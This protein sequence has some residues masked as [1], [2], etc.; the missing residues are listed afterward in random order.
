MDFEVWILLLFFL[1]SNAQILVSKKELSVN[2]GRNVF[3][4]K[5][6]LVFVDTAKKSE[7]R[8]EVVQNDP[9]TQRVGQVRPIMFDCSF[10]PNTVQYI[11]SGSPLLNSDKVKLR[12]YKFTNNSTTSQTFHLDVQIAN[13]SH[14]IVVTRGLR[15]I[16]VP[17][18]NGLS[19]LIDSSV[20]RFYFSGKNNVSCTV[21]FSTYRSLWPIAGQ[22]VVGERKTRVETMRKSCRDFL[23]SKLYYQHVQSPNPDVDYLPLTI[24]LKD[25]DVSDDVSIERFYLPIHIKGALPNSP[26]RSSFL[27]IY[28]MDVNQFVLSTLLPGVISAEDYE[29]DSKD[30]VY[31]ITSLPGGNGGYFVHLDD[32]TIPIDSFVQDDLEHHRIAYQ[33]PSTSLSERRV[34]QAQFTVSD[35]HF[36]SSLPIVLHIAV[37]PSATNAPRIATN[38][39]LVLL[40]GQSRPITIAEL[41]ILDPDNANSVSLYVLGGLRYGQLMKNKRSTIA[42]TL[43]DL[44][45]GRISY[46]HDDS[47]STKDHIKF[48][49]SDGVNT[50]MIT[51]PIIII[52]KDDSAPYL[53]NSIG[54]EVN[55]GETRRISTNMLL[56]HDTDS[57]DD[58]IMYIITQPPSAGEIIKKTSQ[59]DTGTRISKFNQRNIK[60][61]QIFYRHFGNEV[62][63]DSFVFKLR[64]HQDPPNKSEDETF[65]IIINPVYENPPQ[66]APKATRL[67][68]VPETDITYI[69]KDELQ[70]TDIETDDNKLT[71]IITSP[72][73]FV[74]NAGFEEAGRIIATHNFSSVTKNDSIPAISTFKQEDINH[75]KIAYMPPLADIG[76]E[77]RLVRFVY[78]VQDSSGNQVLGQ[79]F[80]I[81]VQPVNDKPP[82]LLVSK[83]L[84]EEGGILGI[85][86]LQLSALDEDTLLED[87]VFILDETPKYGVVQKNGMALAQ[88]G[89]FKID[90]LR[91]NDIRY[92]HDGA[93]VLLDSITL[94]VSDGVNRATKVVP[95]DIVPIDDKAPLL[96][97][98]L[99]P[100]LIVSEGGDAIVTS[101]VLAATDDDTDDS[102]LIF[103]IVK[104]PKYGIMQLVDQP[105]TKFTQK[106]VNGNKVKYIHTGGEVGNNILRDTV[107]FIVSDQN[108]MATGDLPVYDLNITITPVDNSKPA[109]IK[110]L[111]LVV[112]EGGSVTLTPDAVTAKDPDTDPEEIS[113]VITKQPQWGYL[114]NSKPL[115]GS[116]KSRSGIRITTFKLQDIIDKTINYVQANHKGVEPIYDEVEFYATDGKQRSDD[117]PLGFRITP[118]N[119]E[120][121]DVMLQDFSVD[122]GSFKIIDQIIVDAID[123]DVPKEQ[124]TL[125]I[126]QAPDHGDIVLMIQ[127]KNGDMEV[128]VH[129]FTVEELHKG[130]RLKY[131]HDNSEHFRDKFALTVSDGR[132]EVKKLCNISIRA[133]NDEGP[134][135]T[136]NAGLQLEYGDFA[137]ISSASLQS[138]DPDN[139]DNEVIYILMSVPKKGSLQFCTDPFSPTRISECRD[140][141]VGQN[142]TQ[143]DVDMNRVRY[144]HTTSMGNTETDSFL[145]LLTDGTNR[146][147]VE[148]FEIRIRNSKKS[149]LA[150]FNKGLQVRE[151]ERTSISTNNLSASDESTKA[152]EIVF[153]I[154]QRPRLGQIEFIDRHLTSINSF[155]QLDL[156][157]RKVVYNNLNKGDN[158]EDVFKFTVTNGLSQAKDGEF[159]ITIEPLDRVLPSLRVNSLIEVTQGG[160]VELSPLLLK[161]QDPDTASTNVTFI[162]AKPP[163]YGRLYN[164]GIVITR[165]FT[166]S[167]INFGFI[168]YETD[169][170]H[171]GLDNFLFNISDGKHAGFLVNGTLQTKPVICSI[172]I[173][174]LVNDA[175][176]L[177]IL[178]QPDTLEFFGNDRYGFR[179]TNRNLKAIDSDST[180]SQLTYNMI[181]KPQ[182]GHVENVKTKRYVRRRFTQKDVDE[183]SLHYIVNQRKAH[184]NDS[185]T[186]SVTDSRGNILNNQRFEMKW[187]R[188]EFLRKQ[189]ISCEDIGTLTITLKRTGDL[190]QISFVGIKIRDMS[191]KSG[192][193]FFPSSAKQVQFNPGMNQ[194]TWDIR[195]AADSLMENSEKF[196][197]YLEEPINA[198]LGRRTK[199]NIHLI[200]AENGECPQYLGM[201]SKNNKDVV[202]LEETITPISNKKIDTKL[203]FNTF[204]GLGTIKENPLDNAYNTDPDSTPSKSSLSSSKKS[205]T[206][207]NSELNE[208]LPTK[209]KQKKRKRKGRKRKKKRNGKIKKSNSLSQ[210]ADSIFPLSSS[211]LRIQAPQNCTRTTKNL[212]HFDSFTQRM[213]KC[214][215]Y[216]WRVW[217]SG[218]PDE[219]AISSIPAPSVCLIGEFFEGRCYKFFKERKTWEE[220]KRHCNSINAIPSTLTPV[221]SR[222]HYQFLVKLAGKTSF[223]IGLN[224]KQ[225]PRDWEYLRDGSSSIPLL[226][227]TNWGKNQPQVRGKRDRRNCVLVNKRRKWKNKSCTKNS[228]RFIC[229]G[230]PHQK[231]PSQQF[232]VSDQPR[233]QRGRR[234]RRFRWSN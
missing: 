5:D 232:S 190:Q 125:S 31:N 127:T 54:L 197:I 233:R 51:F 167:D 146:R 91:R 163:T 79:Y 128:A 63:K 3:L 123:M 1:T 102:Q 88:K 61:G 196:Q 224:N 171:A 124:L 227:Y 115:K 226:S 4:R 114:E 126:S 81:D 34:F 140:M 187:S 92:V 135:I 117:V 180:S 60:K 155:T 101:S 32:H 40:E 8:V 166:Q 148:T 84:V 20:I 151:G 170:S 72:P 14:D 165:S 223:W 225:A 66:L 97:S 191:A 160:E 131:K 59:G 99:R 7:C 42:M 216:I 80:E 37:R 28:M 118:Q 41:N 206:I 50:I 173:K 158:T 172:F 75:M 199:M 11:H 90:D 26:P 46:Q 65:H 174:P 186:F 229:E 113:F 161:A 183:S 62:F 221:R 106:D 17:E 156:A 86:N 93:E 16:V 230:I 96:K 49:I 154:T 142:F 70:Y 228:K 177:L 150:V 159:R 204:S 53:V 116:Q 157:S 104:Q 107:T 98:N 189:I 207:K 219:S 205:K 23:Y 119:D 33:P 56:A 105:V 195:I 95:I 184:T 82:S 109:I 73:Y 19:N 153:A 194:A 141:M 138:S 129:D 9:I 77:S 217:D 234:R 137:M 87:L 111:E 74:Y 208:V 6:D 108:F 13:K 147:H 198:V 168:T 83:L 2:I 38:K 22:I 78:T 185:F 15:P 110:G 121:P 27:S 52:P 178:K 176:K 143:H 133:L 67:V 201:I 218:S 209:R 30:L 43:E 202:D 44:R 220:A 10:Q 71:Y 76:P 193:D 214:D 222:A 136:K 112:N 213:Y 45:K 134:E 89:E 39:G 36:A 57:L 29:T 85:S 25:P 130:M 100:R 55:E 210:K 103:L 162:I 182:Y 47:E 12:V 120:E 188:I 212:L 144:I 179:I 122:E 192:L 145:F 21:G 231:F 64:D 35:S 203:S 58:N 215:G 48:R 152:D 24:E 18:F 211:S 175:P 94:T 200:N 69:T 181:K 149:N 164:R 139:S 68:H 132:H 169:G